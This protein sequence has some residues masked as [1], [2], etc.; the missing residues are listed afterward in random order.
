MFQLSF[1]VELLP[2]G[3]QLCLELVIALA[4]RNRDRLLLV[5]PLVHEYLAAVMA[6][7][8]GGGNGRGASPLVARATLGLLRV[9]QRLLPYKEGAGDALLRSLHLI[10]RLSPA[11][12]WDMAERIAVEARSPVAMQSCSRKLCCSYRAAVGRDDLCPNI[13]IPHIH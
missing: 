3:A 4:L 8:A 9:A 5:W 12:A 11:T 6:P 7:E 10:L 1:D 2:S 13:A